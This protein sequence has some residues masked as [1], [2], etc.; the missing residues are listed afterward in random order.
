MIPW[1]ICEG[2]KGMEIIL[3]LLSDGTLVNFQECDQLS[4][5]L[6]SL[7]PGALGVKQAIHHLYTNTAV[8]ALEADP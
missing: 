3:V 4:V 7:D 2:K 1:T 6:A 5:C 8:S